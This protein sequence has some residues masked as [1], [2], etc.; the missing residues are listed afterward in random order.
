MSKN[1]GIIS[2]NRDTKG[3]VFSR[4]KNWSSVLIVWALFVIKQQ[5]FS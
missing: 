1:D 2:L 4:S 3:I 5:I